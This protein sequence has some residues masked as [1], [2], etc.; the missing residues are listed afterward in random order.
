MILANL[1]DYLLIEHFYRIDYSKHL[2]NLVKNYNLTISEW[3]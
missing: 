2:A 3:I 1:N